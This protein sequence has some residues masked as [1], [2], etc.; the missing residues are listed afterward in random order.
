MAP[1]T[2]TART[3]VQTARVAARTAWQPSVLND[4]LA[5][6]DRVRTLRR[7]RATLML[8]DQTST[9][10]DANTILEITPSVKRTGQPDLNLRAGAIFLFSRERNTEID[11]ATPAVNCGLRGTQLFV[12][13]GAGGRTFVQVLEGQVEMSNGAGRL[14]LVSGEAGEAAPGQA[15]RRTAVIEARNILQ[16]ALYYPAVVDLDELGLAPAAN[17]PLAASVAA[18]R[19]GDVLGALELLP[20]QP[21]AN[22]TESVYTAAVLLAVGRLDEAGALLA[23]LPPDEPGV[24][25]LG[26]VIAAVKA[27]AVPE[28]AF[29][30]LRTASDAIA[31]SY[32]LQSRAGLDTSWRS[33]LEEAR[34]AAQRATV[35]AP[36]N[37]FAWTRRAE[38][39][40]SFGDTRQAG[41]SLQRALELTPRNAR[42]HALRGFVLSSENR[43]RAAR[44]AFDEAIR[45]DGGLGNGWLGRGLVRIRQGDLPGGRA[46]LQVAATVEPTVSLFHSY[47]G[48]AWSMENRPEDAAR[49]FALAKERDPNDPTPWLYSALEQQLLNQPNLAIADLERSLD[50]TDNRRVYRSRMLLDQDRAVRSAN[51]ARIY[52]NAGMPE[53]ALRE[54]ARAVERDYTNASAHLFL[55]NAFDALRDPRRISLRHE[56]P[57]FNELLLSNLLSPVGGGP[58]SQFVSNQEYSQLL[59]MDGLGASVDA[60]WRGSDDVRS[61]ASLFGTAGPVSAGVDASHFYDSGDRANEEARRSEL[62]AQFKLQITPADV[63]YFLGKWQ[64]QDS[65][66]NFE[67]FDNLPLSTGFDFEEDQKPGLFLGGWRHQW[68]PGSITLVLGGRLSAVQ[69]LR[70]PVTDQRLMLRDGEAFYPSVFTPPP[71][72][73]FFDTYT[74]P[75]FQDPLNPPAIYGLDGE[76]IVYTP[77]L[78]RALAPYWGTGQLV[79]TEFASFSLETQR[80]FE[81]DSIEVQHILQT[82]PNLA[83]FGGR[84]QE[85]E[86]LTR[87]RMEVIRGLLAGGFTTP[88]AEQVSRTHFERENLYFYDY[89]QVAPWLTLVGG[90]AWDRIE[91]PD[92]FR[93]PPVNDGQREE[94]QVSGKAGFTLSPSPWLTVRGAY[95]ESVGGVTFDESVR[96]EPVQ[97][98]GFNQAYR[99]VISESLEGSVETPKYTVYGLSLEGQFPSRTW[100]GVTATQIEQEVDRTLGAFTGYYLNALPTSPAYFPGGTAQSL[101]YRERSIQATLNQLI[102]SQ[103]AVGARYR[104]TESEL[105]STYPEIPTTIDPFADLLD[106]A[107][108]HEV[109]LHADWNSP[110]GLFARLEANWYAQDLEDDA[111]RLIYGGLPRQGDDFWQFNAFLGYRFRRNTCEISAGVLNLLGTDYQL[112]PLNYYGELT[113]RPTAVV[114]CRLTF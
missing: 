59:E 95:T 35:L 111:T 14:A 78:L 48:K 107:S 67:T 94:E 39:E 10:V 46:D 33:R 64:T 26:R 80:E 86:F 44:E 30:D 102:G 60:E 18:Y 98:A 56:T 100:W 85:G 47:L 108:L 58:L 49:D 90:V 72:G 21:P 76:S 96:L 88:A 104:V 83:V 81:I 4:V 50:L 7:S 110:S 12:R 27:Q 24:R 52:R 77:A 25:A 8:H 73:G 2:V 20:T 103:F 87:V 55:A 42:T 61:V 54:A 51:L 53:V 70:D 40:F 62:Y 114:R 37:G 38:L 23:P 43:M 109:S 13:V 11:I 93:S 6:G 91:H 92:N 112:S 16:W 15:P 101:A 82:G 113:R 97:I 79:G 75:A 69:R 29:S 28:V 106:E 1:P 45:L 68:A 19:S 99:T 74:D 84:W 89:L 3:G 41:T 105:R 34:E 36:T 71:L 63:F 9:R 17:T 22:A 32:Y 31:E 65:G 5:V 66:D 57:W